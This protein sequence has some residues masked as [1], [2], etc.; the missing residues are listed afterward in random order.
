MEQN[1]Y[2]DRL[3]CRTASEVQSFLRSWCE[4]LTDEEHLIRSIILQIH[5]SVEFDMKR[6]LYQQM[7]PLLV[8][9][10]GEDDA[11]EKSKNQLWSVIR[12][13]SFMMVYRLL[14]P[15]LD[16]FRCDDLGSIPVINE[17][18]NLAAHGDVD[19]VSYRGR[20][21]FRDFDCLAQ[22]FLDS[23]YARMALD[24]LHDKMIEEP[25]YVA[26]MN[27]EFCAAHGREGGSQSE[28][29]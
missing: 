17:V 5:A 6:I 18:R 27:A 9:M 3:G 16:A 29:T 1:K 7:L 15:C 13:M 28:G 12:R 20:N 24:E 21:P 8:H 4:S 14:K 26:K 22:I 23:Q 11:Y 25:R 2:A 19:S 10:H